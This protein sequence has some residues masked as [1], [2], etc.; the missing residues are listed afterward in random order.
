MRDIFLN[1]LL[2]FLP[3]YDSVK[4]GFVS[5]K[6]EQT[7]S[8]RLCL[9]YF[10]G[11]INGD[12]L[13]CIPKDITLKEMSQIRSH[14]LC[15]SNNHM[16]NTI[17]AFGV[18]GSYKSDINSDPKLLALENR[19]V[20]LI[21][22]LWLLLEKYD[23]T[24]SSIDYPTNIF[25]FL[26]YYNR[27]HA[28]PF[29]QNC[30]NYFISKLHITINIENKSL[31]YLIINE[32]SKVITLYES[33]LYYLQ[34]TLLYFVSIQTEYSEIKKYSD[35]YLELSLS[36]YN[37]KPD[38]ER[39]VTVQFLAWYEK[40]HQLYKSGLIDEFS[41]ELF[42]F[43]KENE[44]LI[45]SYKVYSG[46]KNHIYNNFTCY[47]CNYFN[48]NIIFNALWCCY[49]SIINDKEPANNHR[50]KIMEHSSNVPEFFQA[51]K[52]FWPINLAI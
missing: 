33:K 49:Y 38:K 46:E 32:K 19:P 47:V 51:K 29:L 22:I 6:I 42:L 35:F 50:E 7:I 15:Y 13:V 39:A 26:C 1:N 2:H 41:T 27:M 16:I 23:S 14:L 21:A 36:K 20:C 3:L 24:F 45:N 5:K 4:L 43:C 28:S 40:L 34:H 30:V 48:F 44:E 25:D 9:K 31:S 18:I 11:N 12:H 10:I 37:E 52:N 17:S 8:Q